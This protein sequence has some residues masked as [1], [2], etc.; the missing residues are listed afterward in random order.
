MTLPLNFYSFSHLLPGPNY[1]KGLL[2][3]F[4]LEEAWETD[5]QHSNLMKLFSLQLPKKVIKDELRLL[6]L[7]SMLC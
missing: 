6:T 2:S 4:T 1:L 5:T 7:K 3:I